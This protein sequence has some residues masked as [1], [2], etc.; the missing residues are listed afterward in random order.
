MNDSYIISKMN[1]YMFQLSGK[2]GVWL[3]KKLP[4]ITDNWWQELIINNLS[5]LQREHVINN[6]IKDISGLDL[7]ELLRVLDRN[8]FIITSRFFINNKERGNI[9]KMQEI[10]NSWAHITPSTISK[11]KVLADVDTII[12]LMQ[13]FDAAMSETR[14][15]ENFIFDV[16]EDKEIQPEG[17]KITKFVTEVKQITDE[18]FKIGDVVTLVSDSTAIGAVTN[19]EGNRYT[20]LI[21]GMAQSFYGE[22]IKPKSKKQPTPY[23]TCSFIPYCISNQSSRQQ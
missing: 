3:E 20:V 13:A 6:E 11:E 23:K 21:N 9:R 17:P 10:R 19:I 14:D 4:N 2:I 15:M 16:E 1:G 8:W 12:V 18:G 5:T 7:A 22:Q